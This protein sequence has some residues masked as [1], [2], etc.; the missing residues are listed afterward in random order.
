MRQLY[1]FCEGKT[2]Q[3]FCNQVLRPHLF[4]QYDGRIATSWIAH[5]K[6]HGRVSHGGVPAS[7]ITM[8]R[9]IVNTL[10]SRHEPNE[11]FTTMIDL[12]ALPRDF[13]GKDNHIRDPSNPTP[14]IEALEKAF[15]D[16]IADRRFIPYLQLHE[17]ETLLFADPDAFQIGFENCDREVE[18]LKAI[19]A[20]V[21]NIEHIN[22][23]YLTAPSKRINEVIPGYKGR[24]A[25]AGPDIAEYSGLDIIRAKCP[26]FDS[27]LSRLE[28]LR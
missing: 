11:F 27:W 4:P 24:K 8:R 22:D 18:Q 21:S 26:H 14:Y 15:G 1:V 28:L 9:D 5:S 13:P 7:Y 10:N 6:H 16:D 3:G 23:G 12:Y 25:S 20:S 19:A 17:Y 2:E